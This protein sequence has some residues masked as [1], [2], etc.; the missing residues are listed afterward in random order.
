VLVVL[1]AAGRL[2]GL[3]LL[4]AVTAGVLS[5]AVPY[6][7]DVTAL[8]SVPPR[9]FGV[10]MSSHPALAALAGLVL[11]GQVLAAHEWVG[12]AVVVAANA[13]VV[14]GPRPT[15]VRSTPPRPAPSTSE[16]TR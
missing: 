14:A 3:P 16:E 8:R 13:A 15:P 7:A 4:L 1:A 11:L 12:I 10:F 5:S 6:A 2:G 9:V